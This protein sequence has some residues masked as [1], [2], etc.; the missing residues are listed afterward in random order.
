MAL[1]VVEGAAEEELESDEEL[2]GGERSRPA[3]FNAAPSLRV[4]VIT[5]AA[6]AFSKYVKCSP[7]ALTLEL[8][9]M[10]TGRSPVGYLLVIAKMT[11]LDLM[12]MTWAPSCLLGRA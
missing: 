1:G 11:G 2:L 4:V 9:M 5:L 10:V 6:S 3:A 12:R 8:P 7:L